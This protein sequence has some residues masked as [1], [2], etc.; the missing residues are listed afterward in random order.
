MT[1]H[2]VADTHALL[3][4][5]YDDSKLSATAANL[6]D[7]IIAAG[8][9][10]AI[11]SIVLAEVL[12][13]TEK[14]RIHAAALDHIFAVLRQTHPALVEIPLDQMVVKTMRRIDR[15]QVPDLPDRIVAATALHLGVPIISRD[16]K[17]KA[18][19]LNT[20]W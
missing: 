14:G 5:L 6:M 18:A 10:V 3:W 15:L 11:S 20:I 8:D 9:Q 16:R 4:Y 1:I 2:A 19:V 13:L 7:S 12:Y 17:I